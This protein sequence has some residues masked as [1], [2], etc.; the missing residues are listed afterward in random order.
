MNKRLQKKI[1]NCKIPNIGGLL[2]DVYNQ[3]VNVD[4]A[5]PITTRVDA[6]NMIFVTDIMEYKGKKYNL[7]K[8]FI[9]IRQNDFP[10]DN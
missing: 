6:S 5:R 9:G 1:D 10:E 8:V 3:S 7:T 2:I 4:I